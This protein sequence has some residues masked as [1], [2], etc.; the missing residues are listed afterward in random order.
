MW[1][2]TGPWIR[3]PNVAAHGI[4][5]RYRVLKFLEPDGGGRQ[6]AAVAEGL[7]RRK[8]GNPSRGMGD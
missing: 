7:V 1:F 6:F 4:V 2:L 8:S 5:C 3:I